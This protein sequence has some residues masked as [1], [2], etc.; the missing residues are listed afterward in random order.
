M[1]RSTAPQELYV[2]C[3]G[4][5]YHE[6]ATLKILSDDLVDSRDDAVCTP[7]ACG[8]PSVKWPRFESRCNLEA[9]PTSCASP[10]KS[11]ATPQRRP[12]TVVDRPTGTTR[13]ITGQELEIRVLSPTED[14]SMIVYGTHPAASPGVSES[15]S[16][17]RSFTQC[18]ISPHSK[19]SL[20]IEQPGWHFRTALQA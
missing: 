8:F 6:N 16:S 17:D 5:P 9:S 13:Q 1:T 15:V 11:S 4:V 10:S 14:M 7:R 18:D 3:K 2:V 20:D 12:S 19:R